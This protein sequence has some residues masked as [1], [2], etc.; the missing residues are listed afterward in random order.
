MVKGFKAYDPRV[1][2]H[3]SSDPSTWE[4]TTNPALLIAAYLNDDEF[5]LDAAYTTEIDD[6]TLIAAANVC[7]ETITLA[8]GGTEPRYSLNGSLSTDIEPKE[9]LP[10]LLSAMAG[11]IVN[12]GGKW[13]IQA[14]AYTAPTVTLDEGDL[15]APIRVSA[16]I[17]RRDNFNSVRGTFIDPDRDWQETDF[18]PLEPSTFIAQDSGQQ[19][20]QDLAL[21]FTQSQTMAQR[22][23]KIALYRVRQ[24][25]TV[26]FPANM[27]GWQLKP[28]DTV[29]VDNANFG[30]DAKVFEVVRTKVVLE[31]DGALGCDL[32]LR[33][34]AP[35]IYDWTTGEEQ[36]FDPAPATN[37]PDPFTVANPTALRV[38]T[39]EV[40]A[41]SNSPP[42]AVVS[43]PKATWTAP[44]DQYVTQG[45]QIRVQ[46]KLSSESVFR[47]LALL[48]GD[49]TEASL[50]PQK[51]GVSI[52]VRVRSI[53]SVG[54]P[55]DVFVTKSNYVVGTAPT[56]TVEDWGDFSSSPAVDTT[57]DWGDFSSSPAV[58]TS[59]DWGDFSS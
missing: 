46:W 4:Y 6:A 57:E 45:G 21:S 1:S 13:F 7:D 9:L 42:S 23:S 24:P 41:D 49:A 26:V 37:L 43:V 58:D 48:D 11:R 39:E 15:R 50:P 25:I 19:V 30:W 28:G 14:G 59:E 20:F 52:D 44:A 16:L 51:D 38:T 17:S 29:A 31:D 53:N 5:G 40:A 22:L 54:V 36:A 33:E 8:E 10:A 18:P 12:S 47:E 56:D 34:T 3:D 2:G 27:T 32:V 55:A 35:E